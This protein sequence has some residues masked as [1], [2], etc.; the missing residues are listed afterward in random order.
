MNLTFTH[1]AS[2]LATALTLSLSAPAPTPV[3]LLVAN[4]GDATLSIVDL[5]T[6][7]LTASVAEGFD[8]VVAHEV[9]TSR[10]GRTAYLPIYASSG[11][12][13]PGIDGHIM[14]RIDIASGK[15][16]GTLDFGH[17]VRPHCVVLDPVSGMLYVTT[18]LDKAITIVDPA[19]FK[20]VGSIPTSQEQSHMLALSHDGK[21]GYTANVGPGTVSVLDIA[22][23]KTI[24]V[25]PI[26]ANTQRISVSNDDK[27]VF[28]ADQTT[29]RLAVINAATN[30]I[31]SWITLPSPGYG[32]ASTVDGRNLLVTLL[33][34]SQLAVVDLKTMQVTHTMDVCSRPQEVLP[35]P[36]GKTAYVSCI[37]GH[38]VATIDLA[39]WK[40]T[41]MIDVGERADG[42]ALAISHP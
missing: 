39:T 21:R 25:I 32:T 18:E 36:D 9:V 23:R 41:G 27:L 7:K 38:Q 22:A 5:S 35:T 1:A 20:V 26:S 6:G 37:G 11:V 42:M 13:K 8:K 3:R 19:S 10:N 30:T 31:Q 29:P 4:Q 16:T 34:A 14:L 12:G 15:I 28:T 33:S 17:G 40:V 24:T 2:V